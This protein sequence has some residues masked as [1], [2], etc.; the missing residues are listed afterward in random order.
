[1]V[2][3]QLHVDS[4]FGLFQ[5]IIIKLP[6]LGIYISKRFNKREIQFDRKAG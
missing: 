5:L 4:Y 2:Q 3:Y 6:E 1:M